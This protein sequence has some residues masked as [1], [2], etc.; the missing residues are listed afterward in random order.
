MNFEEDGFTTEYRNCH[1]Y[2]AK[3]I[4]SKEKRTNCIQLY[5]QII[6]PF[7]VYPFNFFVISFSFVEVG[8]A[9]QLI[10]RAT[11]FVALSVVKMYV[12]SLSIL[13]VNILYCFISTLY[14]LF[15]TKARV[16]LVLNIIG[17]WLICYEF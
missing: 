10:S 6:L 5:S 3:P 11:N 2:Q 13:Y 12:V 14:F 8:L 9:V 1:V 7:F 16:E 17:I 4:A 15:F